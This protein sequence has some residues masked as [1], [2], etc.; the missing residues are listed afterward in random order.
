[1]DHD[2]KGR[3]DAFAIQETDCLARSHVV[4]LD[5]LDGS[6]AKCQHKPLTTNN[7]GNGIAFCC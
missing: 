4:E 3:P 7:D 5:G 1:M 6:G 2:K